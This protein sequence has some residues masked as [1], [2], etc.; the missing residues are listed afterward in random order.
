MAIAKDIIAR[1]DELAVRRQEWEREW[2]DIADYALPS[3]SRSMALLGAGGRRAMLDQVVEGPSSREQ[4]RRR[5][6]S[7]A[8]WAVDRL[9]AGVESLVIPQAEKWHTLGVEDMFAAEPDDA[10]KTWLERVR[11]FQFKAR[12]DAKAGFSSSS[13]RAFRSTIAFGTGYMFVPAQ[14]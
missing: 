14:G 2:R 13:Q 5:Y 10:T 4:A 8:L 6:D 9:S 1:A 7:T 11:D 12:Y 3:A